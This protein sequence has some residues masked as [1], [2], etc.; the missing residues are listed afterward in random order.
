MDIIQ[1]LP[2]F[3]WWSVLLAIIPLPI[4][5]WFKRFNLIQLLLGVVALFIAYF[6]ENEVSVVTKCHP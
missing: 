3:T 1:Y 4:F 2:H 6:I 5:W